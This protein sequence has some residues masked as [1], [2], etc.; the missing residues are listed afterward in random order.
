MLIDG[1][2][3]I[4]GSNITNAVVASG[5]SFPSLPDIGELYYL[6]S[7]TAG[8]Y[9][10]N[11][12]AWTAAGSGG[13]GGPFT[14]TGDVTGTIDGGTDVLTLATV[15]S[16]TGSF[17]SS[18]AIPVLTT[19]GKGL[20][21]AVSTSVVIAPAGTLTGPTLA[22]NVVAS[23]LTSVG[24]LS[25]LGV[26]G[27]AS[28]GSFSGAG[29]G[30]TG[31]AASLSI[32]GNAATAS[33]APAAGITGT[34][35]ASNVVSSSLTSVGTLGSLTVSGNVTSSDP[36]S[37]SQLTTKNYVDNA[38]AGLSWKTAV[39]VATTANITLSGTQTIDGVSVAVADR[40]LV[41]NQTTT[42]ANG[43]Y[44]VAS[45]SWT[46][47]TDFDGAPSV[48]EV[49][50]AAVY[51][52][53]GSTLADTMWTETSTV[54]TIGLDPITF[55][56]FSAGGSVAASS[57]TGTVLAS[58]VVTSSLTSLGTL[59]SLTVSG[60]AS[61]GSFSGA[62]TGLTGTATSLNIGGNAAT[63]TSAT[64]ATTASKATSLQ[65]T[66]LAVVSTSTTAAYAGLDG[67]ALPI[68][69]LV[70]ASA[71]AD[72]KYSE[73]IANNDGS[74][75]FQFLNDANG[76]SSAWMTIA[77]TGLTATNITLT[78][79]AITLTGA[80][81]ATSLSTGNLSF[82][83]T[84]NVGGTTG[85]AGQVLTSNG[86]FTPTWQAASG[87]GSVTSVSV[88]TANGVSGSVAT[89]TTTP[90]ITLTL[91]AITPTSV[92]TANV[93]STAALTV[94]AGNA[95][96]TTASSL[97][98]NAG[99]SNTG[100]ATGGSVVLSPGGNVTSGSGVGNITIQGNPSVAY[101]GATGGQANG[102]IQFLTGAAQS[103]NNAVNTLVNRLTI[104][105]GGA[106]TLAGDAGTSGYVMTSAGA[107]APPTWSAAPS[108]L[109]ANLIGTSLAGNVVNSSLTSLGTIASLNATNLTLTGTLTTG[110][111]TG[112][113]GFVLTSNGS[114]A[115][116]WQAAGSGSVT[117]VAV[118]GGTTGLTTSGGPITTSGTITLAGTLAL[119]NGGTGAT[120]QAGAANAVLPTQTSNSGKYLTTDGT[121]ASWATVSGSGTPGG[122]TTQVQYNNAGAFGGSASFT[123]NSGTG[124]V[125]ATTHIGAH[126]GDGS[127]LTNL[128]ATN[129]GSGTVPVAR[130]A[131]SGT[132]SA[133]TYLSGTGIWSTPSV[134]SSSS[135]QGTGSAGVNTA[136]TGVYAGKD[137]NSL[138]IYA[139]VNQSAGT[140]AKYSEITTQN[141][142]RIDF[143]LLNDA[144]NSGTAWM[145]VTRTGIAP[146]LITMVGT[147]INLSGLATT[148]LQLNGSA[149]S[150]G[151]TLTSQGS[152]A[153][154]TWTNPS[155][156]N[157]T[158]GVAGSMP[159]QSAANTTGFT[160]AGTAG[161]LLQS[162][163]TSVPT[164]SQAP[165]ITGLL[166]TAGVQAYGTSAF[167]VPANAGVHIGA[168]N[169]GFPTTQFYSSGAGSDAKLARIYANASGSFI[170]DF[171][172]DANSSAVNWMKVD[173]SGTTATL[174]TFTA[175]SFVFTGTLSSSTA[176][177]A[178][179][180]GIG[181]MV[182]PSAFNSG[183]TSGV[184]IGR[185]GSDSSS[186]VQMYDSGATTGLRGARIL[187]WQ[188]NFRLQFVADDGGSNPNDFMQATRTTAGAGA[189]QLLFT[190]PIT[191]VTA[192]TSMLMTTPTATFSAALTAN[193]SVTSPLFA[194]TG[195]MNITA[196]GQM[197]LASGGT[198]NPIGI[199]TPGGTT[200]GAITITT[201][202]AT[203]GAGGA[204]NLTAGGGSTVQGSVVVNALTL[205]SNNS[206][207]SPVFTGTGAVS[208]QVIGGNA[209]TLKTVDV[210]GAGGA[211]IITA[212]NSTTSGAGGNVS[213]TAGT[214][215]SGAG[216]NVTLTAGNGTS[217]GGSATLKA[218]NASSGTGANAS[219]QAGT[220]SSANGDTLVGN[221]AVTAVAATTG[222]MWVQT[223]NGQPTSAPSAKTGYAAMVVDNT[224]TTPKLWIYG[225]TPTP[226]WKQVTTA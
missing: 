156:T 165:T 20:V 93:L 89:A 104:Q 223:I 55:A 168:D 39:R 5:D 224:G 155:A 177:Q 3:L 113:A 119:A 70:N 189:S 68:L 138:P 26:S 226:G 90:A 159:W 219:L 45:G 64:S 14:I 63:A 126:S 150:A 128:N 120:T 123:F 191:N 28:A 115:P 166:T 146:N 225:G 135:L 33:A 98:L 86:A 217:G 85:A 127:A 216:G 103:T 71:G 43:I 187:N 48:G 145:S 169:G 56:Q 72:S 102:A 116:T 148:G 73:M 13:T 221:G 110:G 153:A 212:A 51:I 175:T 202:T 196:G 143:S 149:G 69:G 194:S 25:S 50:G 184:S 195:T 199:T 82:T 58:N 66:G 52:E 2:S 131:S 36:T 105:A 30:L 94:Q 54:S 178:S 12:S 101:T 133:T 112:T 29:T 179:V 172:N 4:E 84:L 132:A 142:G 211:V 222:F 38:I 167:G 111:T 171:I 79:T 17:G 154:P 75:N 60:T 53:Q 67:N 7:G 134:A 22:S 215:T 205:S 91:G 200:V 157:I 87:S 209:L 193:T 74:I 180:Q 214:A 31:T 176:L 130:L 183:A 129:L 59:G 151:Q 161:A 65:A 141:T 218:G 61:A 203:A 92:S 162:N 114:S 11:G 152:A 80:A 206:V 24:T 81:S 122:A 88:V 23:S 201:G 185:S 19:N 18:T 37:S 210:T 62:G 125:T 77:R 140:D 213:A 190:A 107:G 34:A 147:G 170:H 35:L 108:A 47:S 160:A 97:N 117:S 95:G 197:Q 220:G 144:N 124:A 118:S 174:A 136:V 21:T 83:G 181:T 164:W 40:V 139:L 15:N 208:V 10:Y 1:I 207:T 182:T 32:G 41:K 173:R 9:V 42:S 188:N 76:S 6:T 8:L 16:N 100:S 44:V 46:R 137:G 186:Q 99:A 204:I 49:N 106:W 158:G 27:A 163:G 57:L 109:A 198:A 121:N 96:G 192:S 78:G